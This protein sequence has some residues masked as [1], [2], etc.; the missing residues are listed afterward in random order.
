M[1]FHSENFVREK[2]V[3]MGSQ[4]WRVKVV[5]QV[6]RVSEE[7]QATQEIKDWVDIGETEVYQD[8][9]VQSA[10]L[11]LQVVLLEK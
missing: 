11:F 8:H 2:T 9:Q 4:A 6:S 3:S 7:L 1:Y 10:C 5:P